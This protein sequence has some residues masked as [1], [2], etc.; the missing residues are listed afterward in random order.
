MDL[1]TV[2][3]SKTLGAILWK[4]WGDSLVRNQYITEPQGK[5]MHWYLTNRLPFLE[6]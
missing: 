6:I 4:M 2:G 5:T 1:D 3:L